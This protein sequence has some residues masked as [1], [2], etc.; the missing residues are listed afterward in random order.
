MDK[1]CASALRG[2]GQ[3][4][5]LRGTRGLSAHGYRDPPCS[6]AHNDF[7]NR[8]SLIECEGGEVPRSAAREQN[9]GPSDKPSINEESHMAADPIEVYRVPR[10]VL[11][12]GG[13]S[14]VAASYSFTSCNLIHKS[15]DIP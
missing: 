15:H 2:L 10:L 14:D 11:K 12:Q 13:N 6:L 8:G 7:H 1:I 9:A 5:E 4:F 3:T